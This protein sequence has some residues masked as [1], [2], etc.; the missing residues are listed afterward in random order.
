MHKNLIVVIG[1]SKR[2]CWYKF[3]IGAT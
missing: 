2:I 3:F 1:K